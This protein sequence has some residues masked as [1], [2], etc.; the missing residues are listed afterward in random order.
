MTDVDDLGHGLIRIALPLPITRLPTVNAYVYSGPDGLTVVDPG[1]GH[2]DGYAALR[3]ALDHLGRGL[4][5]VRATVSTHLHPD[6]M[7]LATRLHEEVGADYVMHA[8]AAERMDGYNDWGP[9]RRSVAAMAGRHGAP[10]GKVEVLA[11]DDARPEWAPQSMAPNVLV[12]DGDKIEV[13]PDRTLQVVHTPGH[14]ASHICLI[15]SASGALLSGDHVLPRITPFVPFFPDEDPDNLGTYLDSLDRVE[16]IDPPV[17]YPA[18]MGVVERGAARAEQIALHHQRRL[19]GM[20]DI[21]RDGPTT[22][23]AI[24]EATFT[25]N[26]P[27]MHSRL[28]IQETLAHLEYLRARGRVEQIDDDGVIHYRRPGRAA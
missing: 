15:D 24:M 14:D 28:A 17:T 8:S 11:V 27:P 1:G 13:S 3:A 20:L 5:A 19:R 10:A 2:E 21:L 4:A 26:L 9:I 18:H 7:G 23:W 25:P 22:A 12:E 16:G 6:H